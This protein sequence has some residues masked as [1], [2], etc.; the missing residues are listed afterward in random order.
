MSVGSDRLAAVPVR[1]RRLALLGSPEEAAVALRA[2]VDADCEVVLVVSQPDAR[3][4]RGRATSPTPLKAAALELGI[5]ATDRLDDVLGAEVD[6]G[7][8]VAYGRLVPRRILSQVPM[9]NLHFSLLPR[10]RGAAPVERAVLAGDEVTGVCVMGL[11]PELDAG[12]VFDRAEVRIGADETA[13]ELR[14]R[15][16][17]LGAD[18]L[19]RRLAEGFSEP[20][21]Q[22]GEPVYAPKIQVSELRIDWGSPAV[23]VH[24]IVRVGGAWTTFRDR[25]LKILGARVV[26]HGTRE[27]EVLAP[28]EL[29]G[30]VV[31]TGSGALELTVVQPESR[32]ALE[33]RDWMRGARPDA[34]ER[35]GQ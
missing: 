14:G 19:V 18:V 6:L 5:P 13:A 31:G 21:P 25:R 20:S 16:A 9:V 17:V 34:H 8:V 29:D 26:P 33:A 22:T 24:R 3:R 10:W 1:P 2:L 12:P 27:G 7:V 32:G 15:L 11:D 23:E 4:G 35:L 28:G 30:T